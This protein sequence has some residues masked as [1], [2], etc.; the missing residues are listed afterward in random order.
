MTFIFSTDS[1]I[2][3]TGG[4][5]FLFGAPTTMPQTLNGGAGR[6]FIFGAATSLFED[7]TNNNAAATV[8]DTATLATAFSAAMLIDDT[9]NWT[10]SNNQI[11]DNDTIPHT[12]VYAA[13]GS[14]GNSNYYTVTVGAGET[15]SVDIDAASQ[16][17]DTVLRIYDQNSATAIVTNDNA[18]ALDAGSFSTDDSF[19]TLV[20]T[21]SASVTYLIEVDVAAGG[22]LSSTDQYLLN[23]NVSNHAIGAGSALTSSNTIIGGAGDDILI[24]GNAYN[25]FVF[26]SNDG[27]DI[28]YGGSAG[29]IFDG[30]INDG[31]D[32]FDGGEGLDIVRYTNVTTDIT[33]DL[34]ITTAQDTGGGGVD[35]FIN[36]EGITGG[37]GNDVLTG[38]SGS[39]SSTIIGFIGN[40]ILT[41]GSGR[42]RFSGGEGRDSVFGG[43]GDD[44]HD[45]ERTSELEAQEIYD[46]GDDFDTLIFRADF[47]NSVSTYDLRIA[48][49]VINFESFWFEGSS[50]GILLQMSQTQWNVNAFSEI[51]LRSFDTEAPVIEIFADSTDV[52]DLSG[53]NLSVQFGNV[54]EASFSISGDA[55]GNSVVGSQFADVLLGGAGEDYLNGSGG[56][57]RLEGGTFSDN[58]FGGTGE[59]VLIG[60]SGNDV[61]DGWTGY[62]TALYT[63]LSS[64]VTVDLQ[65]TSAQDTGGGGID[66]LVRIE[67]LV[68]SSQ[69]D[70]LT[71][72]FN[73]NRLEGGDGDDTLSGMG[74]NDTL[75]GGAGNDTLNGGTGADTLVGGAGED[76]LNGGN[77]RDRLDGGADDDILN[78]G[79]D[80]DRLLGGD[81][82]DVLTGGNGTDFLFG[83]TGNDVFVFNDVSE[84]GVGPY[85]RDEIRDW[86]DGDLID[87]SN[88]DADVG[89]SGDQAFTLA[90]DGFT[91]TAGEIMIQ[92]LVR[93][94]VDVQ[95]VSLDIDGD[96][97]ADMQIWVLAS[98]L[99]ASDFIL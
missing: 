34:N 21:T 36:I 31:D 95:L 69:D 6:D 47:G 39:D 2:I 67:N 59:D 29:D 48:S 51:V 3:G 44:N 82:A 8:T 73:R 41:G 77:Q 58:L 86:N 38:A 15:L 63:G 12:T 50:G 9:V 20:N 10:S 91:G 70:V 26:S 28:A 62:D 90:A 4:D 56:N 76:T 88:I 65:V 42:D 75:I 14:A 24:G 52:L 83:G 92:S 97:Q 54:T 87:V 13:G 72:N 64:G 37:S 17:L 19:V 1:E 74:Q 94:G 33:V 18:S 46:G 99:D 32:Y 93:S 45:F 5:D 35:T 66:T 71:G 23:V 43:A 57:D 30:A 27:N 7:I 98:E 78:G 79:G 80:V 25:N 40:D 55:Q 81:G 89:A 85:N 96:A 11:I 84:S 68:G 53:V 49:S 16:G 61:I 22:D 60:G